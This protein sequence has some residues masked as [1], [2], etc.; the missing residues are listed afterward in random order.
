MRLRLLIVTALCLALLHRHAASQSSTDFTTYADPKSGTQ[1]GV[2]RAMPGKPSSAAMGLN[3]TSD[4]RRLSISSVR[5]PPELVF[6]D[7]YRA[8][9]SR[10]GQQLTRDELTATAFRLEG[11]NRNGTDFI[12]RGVH[13]ITG[14]RAFTVTYVRGGAD[15][16]ATARQIVATFKP[17]AVT[18]P[19]AQAPAAPRSAPAAGA[20]PPAVSAP[21]VLPNATVAA[22]DKAK[23]LPAQPQ[24]ASQVAGQTGC[25]DAVAGVQSMA[26][27]LRVELR[28][29]ET[30]AGQGLDL[31][32]A[33]RPQQRRQA[34]YLMVTL[35]RPA[36]FVGQGFYT[37]N[38]AA[39]APFGLKHGV[40]KTRIVVPLYV[41]GGQ[42]QRAIKVVPVLAGELSV[43]A[44]VVAPSACGEQVVERLPLTRIAVSP[45]RPKIEVAD[46]GL[47]S[48]ARDIIL[49]PAG[50]R[51]V[52]V[53]G[54]HT[55]EPNV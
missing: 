50:D 2:P 21:K 40:D 32:W 5:F 54:A 53:T 51:A 24:S 26:N 23:S 3:W 44:H 42:A 29:R 22:P 46:D 20:A 14:T 17:S 1:F 4:D 35:D 16:Q 13:S 8:L 11:T 43:A 27:A 25:A 47:I 6:Q 30:A 33:F 19:K 28:Q 15:L 36:R 52:E 7:I 10:E 38:P 34:I 18:D 49:S 41:T 55:V 9:K 31:S 48:E 12:V 37:L 45:G 39:R